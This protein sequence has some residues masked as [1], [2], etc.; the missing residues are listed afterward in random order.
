MQTSYAF[1]QSASLWQAI[2]IKTETR[3]IIMSKKSNIQMPQ[4]T[5]G[6][7]RYYDQSKT[8]IKLKPEHILVAAA[9]LVIIELAIKFMF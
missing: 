7:V 6:L 1:L 2:P 4:S 8:L 9:A 5:A 3:I